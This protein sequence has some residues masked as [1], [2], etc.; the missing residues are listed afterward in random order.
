ML[1][2]SV[3][4]AVDANRPGDWGGKW[5]SMRA[6]HA[7]PRPFRLRTRLKVVDW[8]CQP[9]CPVRLRHA[10]TRIVTQEPRSATAAVWTSRYGRA[11]IGHVLEW[12]IGRFR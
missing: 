9:D 7:Q 8:M 6:S 4:S 2:A 10:G 5:L 12:L 1:S 3:A 11:E